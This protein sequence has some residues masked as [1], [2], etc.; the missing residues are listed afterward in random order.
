MTAYIE[1]YYPNRFGAVLSACRAFWDARGTINAQAAQRDSFS[2][3]VFS[4]APAVL[5]EGDE[6]SSP[7]ELTK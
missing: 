5:F 3:I 2:A 7:E 1:Q 4:S 6:T